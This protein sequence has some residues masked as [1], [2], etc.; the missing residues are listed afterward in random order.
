MKIKDVNFLKQ[1]FRLS[2][3][4]TVSSL[5][6]WASLRREV[7]WWRVSGVSSG[8]VKRSRLLFLFTTDHQ[9]HI[10]LINWWENGSQDPG[11]LKKFFFLGLLSNATGRCHILLRFWII[12]GKNCKDL[13]LRRDCT[14]YLLQ[15]SQVKTLKKCLISLIHFLS[16]N[17][18][19]FYCF[20]VYFIISKK[21]N[22]FRLFVV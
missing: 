8:C 22:R 13:G 12:F 15:K 3:P 21:S 11:N 6:S 10:I 5:I 2:T 20:C 14:M 18:L 1:Y 9:T 4:R 17:F 7:G 16:S 19:F